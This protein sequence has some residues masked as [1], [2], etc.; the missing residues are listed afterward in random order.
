MIKLVP[1]PKFTCRVD[2]STPGEET[3]REIGITFRHKTK[4]AVQNWI[5]SAVNKSDVD[6]LAEVIDSWSDVV[7]ESGESISYSPQALADLLQNYP[8]AHQEI[9]K[10][11]LRELTE[12]KR[13]N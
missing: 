9:F 13:K 5:D 8:A 2:L 1:N 3:T 4:D 6:V 10:K 11:Y 7:S 12:S